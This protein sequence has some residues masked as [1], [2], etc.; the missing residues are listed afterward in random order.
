MFN[1]KWNGKLLENVYGTYNYSILMG[2]KQH[3]SIT[4]GPHLVEITSIIFS[5]LLTHPTLETYPT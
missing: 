1:P 4:G 5:G 3:R 2:F